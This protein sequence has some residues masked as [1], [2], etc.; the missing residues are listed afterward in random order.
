MK[1]KCIGGPNHREFHDV[2]KDYREGDLVRLITYPKVSINVTMSS[3]VDSVTV[4]YNFYVYDILKYQE[5][6]RS[7]PIELHFLRFKDI[8][9]TEALRIALVY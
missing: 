3:L 4:D 2:P 6:D 7:Q 9:I 8:S 1:L 5:K